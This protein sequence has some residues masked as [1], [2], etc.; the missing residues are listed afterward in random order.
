[1]DKEFIVNA[2]TQVEACCYSWLNFDG[3]LFPTGNKSFG[4]FCS[5]ASYSIFWGCP[6]MLRRESGEGY[7]MI[8]ESLEVCLE[9]ILQY[10]DTL[11]LGYCL[12]SWQNCCAETYLVP[13][14]FL[15]DIFQPPPFHWIPFIS[16][17]PSSLVLVLSRFPPLQQSFN[18]P[19][20]FKYC[21]IAQWL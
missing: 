2:S 15:F 14:S 1:M 10:L 16:E 4:C 8:F 6:S 12:I 17:Y 21:P 9:D 7:P 5:G 20:V 13:D 19:S 11:T 18:L 3:R